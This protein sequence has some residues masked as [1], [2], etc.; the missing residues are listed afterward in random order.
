MNAKLSRKYTN[1]SIRVT[2]A[3]ILSRCKFNDK[4]VMSMTGHKSVQSLTIYQ[5]V[6]SKTKMNMSK[7]LHKSLSTDDDTLINSVQAP[8]QQKQILQSSPK[9]AIEAPQENINKETAIIP[10]EPTFED[11][12]LD[13]ID[14][15]KVLCDAEN[16]NTNDMQMH[17][18]ENS[19][20]T[21]MM[22]QRNSP[23]F[24]NC[25]IGNININIT[26]K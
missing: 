17:S 19:M 4:E 11:D 21:M 5:R 26:K 7:V 6:Q 20:S 18:K 15:L 16:Q 3:S 12:G 24:A 14:W 9:K 13:D 2:G 23:M 25:K 1:H 22:Q 10:L 8:I